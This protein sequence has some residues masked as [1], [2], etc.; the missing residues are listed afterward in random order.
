MYILK[1]ILKVMPTLYEITRKN[2]GPQKTQKDTEFLLSQSPFIFSVSLVLRSGATPQSSILCDLWAL[3]Q[4]RK[5]WEIS[6][7]KF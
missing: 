2:K 7:L 6:T 3:I 1:E 5:K 4:R